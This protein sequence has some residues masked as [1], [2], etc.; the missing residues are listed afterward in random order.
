[1][2]TVITDIDTTSWT[3][4]EVLRVCVDRG[5]DVPEGADRRTLDRLVHADVAAKAIEHE[6]WIVRVESGAFSMPAP[7]EDD[8]VEAAPAPVVDAPVVDDPF[9]GE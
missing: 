6:A 1:M 9:A 8:D 3:D 4:D 2:D 5:I 7:A